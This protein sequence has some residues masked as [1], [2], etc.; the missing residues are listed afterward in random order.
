MKSGFPSSLVIL[1]T[2]A[3]AGIGRIT[4][5]RLA[6]QGHRFVLAARS[7]DKLASLE[8]ELIAQGVECLSVPTDVSDPNALDKLVAAA[9]D[10]FGR[11]DVLINNAGIECFSPIDELAVEN[12]AQT[13]ETNLTGAILL[14]RVVVPVMR[15][16]KFGRIVNLGSIAGKHGPAYGAVYG[17]TKAGLIA[18]TQALRG[19]LRDD[20]ILSTVICPGF[21]TN[22]GIYDEM[23]KATGKK[24][25]AMLGGTTAEAVAA[26]IEKAI[27]TAPPEVIINFPWLRPVF[28]FRDVFPRLGEAVFL[29]VTLRFLKRIATHSKKP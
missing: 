4:V 8:T 29:G 6:R 5:Q 27:H 2:G 23:V 24:A 25:P 11:I 13:I 14:T 21:A 16:Q 26:A 10:R 28:L 1:V 12:I 19:E 7:A 18:F 3:S 15:K 20:G 17:A 9:V 22:G